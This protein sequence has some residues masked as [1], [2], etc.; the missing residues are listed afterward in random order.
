MHGNAT[1]FEAVIRVMGNF[2]A[3]SDVEYRALAFVVTFSFD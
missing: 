2:S 1:L 3:N